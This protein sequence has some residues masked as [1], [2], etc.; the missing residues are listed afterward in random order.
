MNQAINKMLD[1]L[2]LNWPELLH[3]GPEKTIGANNNFYDQKLK[4]IDYM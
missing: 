3:V 1:F 4:F 2:L